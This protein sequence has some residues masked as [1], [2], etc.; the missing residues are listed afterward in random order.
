MRLRF[1][2]PKLT[3]KLK[4]IW[5]FESLPDAFDEFKV[6]YNLNEMKLTMVELMNELYLV[7]EIYV[8]LIYQL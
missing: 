3:M 6:N 1:N 5:C 8:R 4:F 7:K 2:T